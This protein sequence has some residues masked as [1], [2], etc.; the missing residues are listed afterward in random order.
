MKVSVIGTGY[1][2]LVS[3][4]CLAEMGHEVI[5]VDADAR[6]ISQ[7]QQGVSPIFEQGLEPLLQK[8][9]GRRLQTTTQLERAVLDT[10]LS[11]IAVGT[12][13]SGSEIDLDCVKQ[14]SLQIGQALRNKD[15]YH[16]VVV[17]STVVPSTTEVT[18]VPILEQAS[19][20]RAGTDFG[21]GVNPEFLTEGEAVHDFMNPDRIVL[22]GIDAKTLTLL[23]QLYA[24]FNGVEKLKTNPRTAE[25]IKYASNALLATMIFFA[26]EIGN[27]GAAIGGIDVVDVMQG[28]QLSQY[29]SLRM[30]DGSRKSPGIVTFLSAGCGFGG[31]CLP[32]DVKALVAHGRK[33]GQP[34]RL[35][36]AVI[37]VNEQ[38]SRQ[39]VS[40]L[41]KHY[42]SLGGVRVAVLGLSFR[43]GT[44]DMRESPA[45]PILRALA[46]EGA[47]LKA[48]DPAA[49]EEAREVFRDDSVHICDDLSETV[50]DAQAIVLVTRWDEFHRLPKLLKQ[51]KLQPIVVDGRR[52]L[53]KTEFAQYEGI[54]L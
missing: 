17:K 28:V 36:D 42:P 27:L 25:M 3:G 30:P 46:S 32:K 22:G 31:S 7:I 6:K 24:G 40:L 19:G 51:H 47:A 5:C 9:I 20:K 26:N 21:V 48:Y 15:D 34:M 2:G 35:L 18:V 37:E 41:R 49:R 1:V 52:M 10:D 11:L 38:Q 45:I 43:P 29:L 14:V 8:H 44:N 4:V 54:G 23:E 12:P 33:T 16:V 13:F 39:V 53:D 50:C